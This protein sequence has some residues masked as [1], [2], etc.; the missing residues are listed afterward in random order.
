MAKAKA[1]PR[2]RTGHRG[3]TGVTGT[4]AKRARRRPYEYD[5]EYGLRGK[6]ATKTAGNQARKSRG[7]KKR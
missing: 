7:V 1:M 5:H 2:K 6:A 4:V 3:L